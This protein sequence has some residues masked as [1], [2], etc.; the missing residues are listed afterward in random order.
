MNYN[1]NFAFELIVS[2]FRSKTVEIEK[3]LYEIVS[4]IQQQRRNNWK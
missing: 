2:V 1:I 3:E 4:K